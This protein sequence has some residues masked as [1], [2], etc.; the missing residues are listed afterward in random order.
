ML[1]VLPCGFHRI[2]HYGLLAGGSRKAGL[3]LARKLLGVAARLHPGSSDEPEDSPLLRWRHDHHRGVRTVAAA[4]RSAGRYGS[5][6]MI[7]HDM[8]QPPTA[9]PQPPGTGPRTP[10]VIIEAAPSRSSCGGAARRRNEAACS[11]PSPLFPT[12]VAPLVTPAENRNPRSLRLWSAPIMASP[13][14][15]RYAAPRRANL[16]SLP[17]SSNISKREHRLARRDGCVLLERKNRLGQT[18]MVI[19]L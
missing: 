14:R 10:M 16:L 5:R 11:R 2:R 19:E 3:A 12:A 7:R 17:V 8:S 1:H 18:G 15:A 6:P 9:G 13:F 4:A